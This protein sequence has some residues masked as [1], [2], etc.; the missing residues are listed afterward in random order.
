MKLTVVVTSL[1]LIIVVASVLISGCTQQQETVT[2]NT[3]ILPF[4]YTCNNTFGPC[5]T[6][7]PVVSNYTQSLLVT[8]TESTEPT[9]SQPVAV[10][11]YVPKQTLYIPPTPTPQPPDPIVGKWSVGGTPY[12]GN[13]V[14]VSDGYGVATVGINALNQITPFTWQDN[15][16][17]GNGDY[18]YTLS[19][20]DGSA[21]DSAII[22]ANGTMYCTIIP[23]TN[24]LI[25]D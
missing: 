10:T 4:G 21:S 2:V 22:G 11:N 12:M 15:G 9:F 19:F 24:Y 14:F 3:T 1:A 17:D 18:L 20:S 8:Q 6:Q 7:P 5:T 13:I 16:N 25:K 23:E